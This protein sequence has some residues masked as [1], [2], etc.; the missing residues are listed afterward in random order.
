MEKAEKMETL[1]LGLGWR[2]MPVGR[3]FRTVG[4]TI[5]ESDLVNF[6][7]ATGMLEV[8]FTNVTYQEVIKGRLVPGALVYSFA[9]GLLIQATM[10]SVGLAFLDM[11]LTMKGPTRVGDTIH[12][13]V[14]VIESRPSK[15]R[16]GLALVRT[17]NQVVRQDGGV[18]LE[19]T[20]LRMLK[21]HA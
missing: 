7:S 20:P 3:K 21:E 16:P 11:E 17:R 8:L 4:R 1:G 9:E 15:S 12:V 13:E 6:I 5:T 2:D 10:Q 18:A 19:Y 14:E